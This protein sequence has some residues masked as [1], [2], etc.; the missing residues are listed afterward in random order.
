[1]GDNDSNY[2]CFAYSGNR[3]LIANFAAVLRSGAADVPTGHYMIKS[4]Y[5]LWEKHD[6]PEANRLSFEGNRFLGTQEEVVEKMSDALGQMGITGSGELH[7]VFAAMKGEM[8]IKLHFVYQKLLEEAVR[9][10]IMPFRL[11]VTERVEAAQFLLDCF[12]PV[13]TNFAGRR[14]ADLAGC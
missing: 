7:V 13:N 3:S 5:R 12:E 1:M 4:A 2:F 14:L 6:E 11:L 9:Q 8:Y 10:G